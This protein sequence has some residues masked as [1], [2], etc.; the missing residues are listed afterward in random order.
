M[1]AVMLANRTLD[2]N[3]A[4]ARNFDAFTPPALLSKRQSD[5]KAKRTR[6]LC[7]VDPVSEE[8][9]KTGPVSALLTDARR[10]GSEKR[11]CHL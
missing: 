7:R 4:A 10:I 1:D 5:V 11:K 8:H 3:E 6:R 9:Q 2:G